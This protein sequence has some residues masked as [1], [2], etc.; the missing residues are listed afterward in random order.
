[1]TLQMSA[2]IW[3]VREVKSL[4]FVKWDMG[5]KCLILRW[6]WQNQNDLS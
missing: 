4:V 5:K 1:M 3:D 6:L 2:L